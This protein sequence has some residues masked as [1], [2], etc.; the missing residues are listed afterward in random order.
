MLKVAETL[1]GMPI[2]T[3]S[4]HLVDRPKFELSKAV[5]VT[6]EYRASFD[7]WARDFFGCEYGVIRATDASTGRV[8]LLMSENGLAHLR[9]RT[10]ELFK[11]PK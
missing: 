2:V 3:V 7:A 4:A 5:P 1:Y 9:K 8:Q 11:V 6:P 10:G